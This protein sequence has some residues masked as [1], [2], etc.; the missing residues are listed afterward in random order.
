MA[1]DR[2]LTYRDL[3][4]W[5]NIPMGTLNWWVATHKIPHVRLGPR[6]VRFVRAEIEHFLRERCAGGTH[7]RPDVP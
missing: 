6:T 2:L 4:D 5:L 7:G 3:A 1:D